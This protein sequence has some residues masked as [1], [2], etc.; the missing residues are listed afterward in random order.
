MFNELRYILDSEILN[1]CKDNFETLGFGTGRYVFVLSDKLVLK[2]GFNKAGIEQ[3]KVEV[4]L[5]HHPLCANI[6]QHHKDYLWVVMDRLMMYTDKEFT[7]ASGTTHSDRI[8]WCEYHQ[9]IELDNIDTMFR[10]RIIAR[11]NIKVNDDSNWVDK[12]CVSPFL[13]NLTQFIINNELA[14][15]DLSRCASWGYIKGQKNK[16]MLFDYGLSTDVWDNFYTEKMVKLMYKDEPTNFTLVQSIDFD[17]E[18]GDTVAMWINGVGG[19]FE[20]AGESI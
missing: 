11:Y 13:V 16:P 9:T 12:M 10:D 15:G 4:G 5:N 14:S 6:H 20:V 8:I 18:V 19:L 7:K 1:Y 2:V 3:N 17:Y